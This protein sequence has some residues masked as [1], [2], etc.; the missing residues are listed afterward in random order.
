MPSTP[1]FSLLFIIVFVFIS[2]LSP[3]VFAQGSPGMG[4]SP[5]GGIKLD[6]P[7][8]VS[9]FTELLNK[10]IDFLIEIGAVLLVIIVLIG[11]Y[12]ILFATGDPTKFATGKKTII[13]A[14]I[15]YAI[16]L[17]AKGIALIIKDFLG[18]SP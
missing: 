13:Y 15:G 16:I 3:Y 11:A 9:N 2:L 17:L 8:G 14:A 1:K 7:L 10:I 4:G 5:D 18:V 12:Q 6:N